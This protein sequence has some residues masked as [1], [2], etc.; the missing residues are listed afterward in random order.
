[1]IGHIVPW[2]KNSHHRSFTL[3]IQLRDCSVGMHQA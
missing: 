2:W 3:S 1:L